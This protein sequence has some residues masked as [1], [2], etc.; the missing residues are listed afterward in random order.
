MMA[1]LN[2]ILVI[3]AIMFIVIGKL[4]I[5]TLFLLTYLTVVAT[6]VYAILKLIRRD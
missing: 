6:I 1:I 4:F 3:I 2:W 5:Y